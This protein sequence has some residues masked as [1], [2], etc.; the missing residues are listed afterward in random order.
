MAYQ[1]KFTTKT[2]L[3]KEIGWSMS[4]LEEIMGPPDYYKPH[5]NPQYGQMAMYSVL[6]AKLFVDSP[7]VKWRGQRKT[8]RIIKPKPEELEGWKAGEIKDAKEAMRWAIQQTQAGQF[9]EALLVVRNLDEGLRDAFYGMVRDQLAGHELRKAIR[10]LE[11]G[12]VAWQRH[13]IRAL[14]MG[15]IGEAVLIG[16]REQVWETDNPIHIEAAYRKAPMHVFGIFSRKY[17]WRQDREHAET[18]TRLASSMI[19]SGKPWQLAFFLP[20]L[21]TS[22][23]ER[24]RLFEIFIHRTRRDEGQENAGTFL[25]WARE[26]WTDTEIM[27]SLVMASETLHG[28]AQTRNVSNFTNLF[29]DI[30]RKMP[31]FEDKE[32]DNIKKEVRKNDEMRGGRF[33]SRVF[34]ISLAKTAQEAEN[35]STPASRPKPMM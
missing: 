27:S 13:L 17:H 18:V 31:Q 15:R 3:A 6:Q 22:K 20:P 12:G 34:R 25:N 30:A 21:Q 8:R 23:Q 32:I 1:K 24:D 5:P 7:E 33:R 2:T 16:T 4:L 14:R 10:E 29:E 26:R 9:E 28:G 11:L 19:S 35:R